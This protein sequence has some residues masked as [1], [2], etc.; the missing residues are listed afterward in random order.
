[1]SSGKSYKKALY[2]SL[3]LSLSLSLS[4]L[5]HHVGNGQK[6]PSLNAAA[7]IT[8]PGDSGNNDLLKLSGLDYFEIR[9]CEFRNGAEG[10]SGIDMVSCHHGII[11]GNHFENLGSNSIQ[12][13]DK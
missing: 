7:A 11:Q 4:A 12:C 1:V 6:Y 9:N 3:F 13:K 5:T 8:Q 2:T 10:G